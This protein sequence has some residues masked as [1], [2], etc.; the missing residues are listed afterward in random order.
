M[1][2]EFCGEFVEC[3]YKCKICGCKPCQ[4]MEYVNISDTQKISMTEWIESKENT[5]NKKSNEFYCTEC[6]IKIGMPLGT[7]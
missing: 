5:L 7:A 4:I 6:Y 1:C 3:L 2:S